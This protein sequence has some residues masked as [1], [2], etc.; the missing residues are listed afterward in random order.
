MLTL[1]LLI[2]FKQDCAMGREEGIL[3]LHMSGKASRGDGEHSQ[4]E[5]VGALLS[6]GMGEDRV[7][8]LEF[9]GEQRVDPVGEGGGL[10]MLWEKG[11]GHIASE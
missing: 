8:C 4:R 2:I 10:S 1:N 7:G 3:G 5:L 6:S 11:G 9:P